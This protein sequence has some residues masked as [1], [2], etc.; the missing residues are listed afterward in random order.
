MMTV[1]S[2]DD[3]FYDDYD[4]GDDDDAFIYLFI[5]AFIY[6]TN[7]YDDDMTNDGYR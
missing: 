4:D 2:C 6:F 1:T 5:Y 3:A 7:M